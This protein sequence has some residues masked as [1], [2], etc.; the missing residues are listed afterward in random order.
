MFVIHRVIDTATGQLSFAHY[1]SSNSQQLTNTIVSRAQD[2]A[3]DHN[4]TYIIVDTNTD[5]VVYRTDK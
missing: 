3:T 2:L 4:Q 5:E 1:G